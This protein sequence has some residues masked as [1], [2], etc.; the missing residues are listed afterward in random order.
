VATGSASAI[1]GLAR[2]ISFTARYGARIRRGV[3]LGGGGLYFV[4]WQT[5]YLHAAAQ[6]G[7]DLAQADRFVG[8]SAG[9]VVATALSG[10]HLSRL[11]AQ[12]SGLSKFPA[13]LRALAPSQSLRP[14]QQRALDLFRSAQDAEPETIRRI[15]FAALAAIT[16]DPARMRANLQLVLQVREWPSPE[17]HVTCVD[18][19]SG[20]RCVITQDSG[21]RPARAAAASSAV[22][23][24]FAPQPIGDRR[25]MDGGVSGSG[26]HLDLL[27]G[28]GSVLVLSLTDGSAGV[29]SQMTVAA[30]N[31]QRECAALEAS[32]TTMMLRFPNPVDPETLM[33][34]ESVP[35]ALAD[36]AAQA[37]QDLDQLRDLWG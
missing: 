16:P 6:A 35:A 23:G 11:H 2:P 15:G 10:G 33:S 28:A 9:S 12:V 4:A 25:C 30:G 21:I 18:A 5:G 24:L 7:I 17:L 31:I 34:P 20:E 29:P 22:P 32:G 14:S 27:A 26:T 19:Y 8:T 13:A 3:C 37:V 36:G 1:D